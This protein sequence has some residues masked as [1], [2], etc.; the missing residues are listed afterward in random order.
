V[1]VYPIK[2]PEVHLADK[3]AEPSG[4]DVSMIHDW[5]A[6]WACNPEPRLGRPGAL[7]PFARRALR[8]AAVDVI[9]HPTVGGL[10]LGEL[11][12]LVTEV[13]E[14]FEQR[15]WRCPDTNLQ[16]L[17]LVFPGLSSEDAGILDVAHSA[18]KTEV[19]TAG[20]MFAQFHP[21]CD[22]RSV[23]N[24]DIRAGFAPLPLLVFR[25]MA[26]HD[27]L[28]LSDALDWFDAY[29]RRFGHPGDQPGTPDLLACSRYEAAT[30]RWGP[31]GTGG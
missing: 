18:S 12:T 9:F 23:R 15:P 4:S 3:P 11:Q 5:I 26:V 2:G 10:G 24:H 22:V 28:F 14:G 13:V 6:R 19:V 27:V 7:C 1:Q 29:R 17:V 31:L 30:T 20:L 16:S 21:A 25:R 8:A